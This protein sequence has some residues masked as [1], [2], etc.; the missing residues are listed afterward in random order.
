ML[1]GRMISHLRDN[2]LCLAL[3][4][5]FAAFY[6]SET[7]HDLASANWV[8]KVHEIKLVLDAEDCLSQGQGQGQKTWIE[9]EGDEMEWMEHLPFAWAALVKEHSMEVH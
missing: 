1:S 6:L 3:A 4:S 7:K 8:G 5:T 2:H 9:L